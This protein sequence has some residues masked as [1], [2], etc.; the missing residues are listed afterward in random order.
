MLV[1]QPCQP[2]LYPIC[3]AFLQAYALRMRQIS[4]HAHCSSG[5]ASEGASARVVTD[6]CNASEGN[7][8]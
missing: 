4:A 6:R 8:G 3:A 5:K 7:G 1:A 2:C